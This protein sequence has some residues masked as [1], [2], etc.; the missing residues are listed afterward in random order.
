MVVQCV[1]AEIQSQNALKQVVKLVVL[2]GALTIIGYLSLLS[3]FV[4][5]SPSDAGVPEHIAPHIFEYTTIT[6]L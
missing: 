1:S 2:V 4:D 5:L 3:T 6:E